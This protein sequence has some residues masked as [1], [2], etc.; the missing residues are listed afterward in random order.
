MV[1]PCDEASRSVLAL[2]VLGRWLLGSHPRFN[3]CALEV[4]PLLVTI[5]RSGGSLCMSGVLY[6]GEANL[7][8]QAYRD[9]FPD[10]AIEHGA[11]CEWA[12]VHG[13][14]GVGVASV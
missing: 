9:A 14:R 4:A 7:L 6:E 5:L 2:G 12:V 11:D 10:L 8:L 1:L 13:T 3:L